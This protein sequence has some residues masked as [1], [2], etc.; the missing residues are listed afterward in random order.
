MNN[1][2]ATRVTLT[3][4]DLSD[5]W[6]AIA[7]DQMALLKIDPEKAEKSTT[8]F[9]KAGVADR[10]RQPLLKRLKG[11]GGDFF[12]VADKIG[13]HRVTLFR[14]LKGTVVPEW[15][16]LLVAATAYGLDWDGVFPQSGEAVLGG[17]CRAMGDIRTT[18]LM[19]D[20]RI[21]E[22]IPFFLMWFVAANRSEQQALCSEKV[23]IRAE[24]RKRIN[25]FIGR[26]LRQPVN[27][28]EEQILAFIDEWWDAYLLFQTLIQYQWEL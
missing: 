25:H 14:W 21:C 24:S 7:Q 4:G 9:F 8:K 12:D 28:N 11:L 1:E 20:P 6:Q 23:A 5:V 15:D 19:R 10:Y 18:L 16:N 26:V 22:A 13:I 27:L 3:L 17:V 2:I